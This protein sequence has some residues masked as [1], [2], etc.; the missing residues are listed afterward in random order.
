MVSPLS[1]NRLANR[2]RIGRY[3]AP[4]EENTRLVKSGTSPAE[5]RLRSPMAADLTSSA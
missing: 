4:I 3:S 2:A 5:D 1:G